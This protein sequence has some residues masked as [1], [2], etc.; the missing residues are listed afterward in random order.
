[1]TVEGSTAVV[2]GWAIDADTPDPIPV[3]LYVG[4]AGTA[5]VADRDRP[6]VGAAYP[7]SGSAHGFAEELA[8]P[9]GTSNVCAYAINAGA[10][11]NTHLGCRSVTVAA[12]PPVSSGRAPF[13]NFEAV[14]PGAGGATVAGWAI[15]PDTTA[16]I[17]VHVYADGVGTAHAADLGRSDVAAAFPGTGAA[18]GFAPFVSMSAGAHN[19]CVY[20]INDGAG[21]HTFLGCRAVTVP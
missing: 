9:A 20:A 2:T 4:G 3:H 5:V 16:P 17:S 19:V 11:A 21:G 10:G 1:M 14:V 8:L 6:D 12:P 15:D 7:T 18:H 13:G